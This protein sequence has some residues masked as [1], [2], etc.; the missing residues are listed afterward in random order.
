[1]FAVVVD[2]VIVCVEEVVLADEIVD[3]FV[4]LCNGFVFKFCF[5]VIFIGFIV[6]VFGCIFG[7][8]G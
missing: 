6:G 1:M 8:G 2:S 5:W 3:D 4:V 7:F